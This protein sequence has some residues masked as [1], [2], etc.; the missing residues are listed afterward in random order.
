MCLVVC[1]SSSSSLKIEEE[2]EEEEEEKTVVH[3]IFFFSFHHG[4]K[5]REQKKISLRSSHCFRFI[6]LTILS[7]SP[8][9][10]ISVSFSTGPDHR[11]IDQT[12]RSN[13]LDH[14]RGEIE[15]DDRMLDFRIS[16]FE[17]S[18]DVRRIER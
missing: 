4:E 3:S 13:N 7:L 12:P 14:N 6:F 8:G 5:T 17:R 16:T 15:D 11:S 18:F 10:N 2:E 1:L 9:S